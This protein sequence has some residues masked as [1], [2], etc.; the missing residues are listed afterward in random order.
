MIKYICDIC[1]KEFDKNDGFD[2]KIESKCLNIAYSDFYKEICPDC[3]SKIATYILK[4]H[5]EMGG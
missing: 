2:L 1:G 3:R 4:I 5:I